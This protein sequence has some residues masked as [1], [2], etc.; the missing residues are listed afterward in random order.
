MYQCLG[1]R[2]R[3]GE[4]GIARNVA[5]LSLPKY[6]PYLHLPAGD[7]VPAVVLDVVVVLAAADAEE[8]LLALQRC[9]ANVGILRGKT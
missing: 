6:L 4:G 1:K 9:I 7:G 8:A 5:A 2:G 3:G